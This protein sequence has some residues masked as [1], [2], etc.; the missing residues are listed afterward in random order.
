MADVQVCVKCGKTKKSTDFYKMRDGSRCDMCKACL[1]M[2]IDNRQPDTFLWILEKFDI[3]YIEDKWVELSNKKYMENPA[4][5][6]PMSVI[7]TYMRSM[8][9]NQYKDYRYADSD[10]L[11]FEA[12]KEREE[13]RAKR[14]ALGMDKEYEANLKA[15]L[16]NGEITE[17]E[18]NTLSHT[19]ESS[20]EIEENAL[21]A[22]PQFIQD[23][24]QLNE[25]DIK[26]ELSEDDIKYLAL[27]WGLFYKPSQWVWLEQKYQEYANQY[28]LSV[29]REDVLRKICKVSLKMDEALDLGDTKTFK[30]LSLTYESLRKSGKFTEAQKQEEERR[31]IDS[32]GELVAF[33]EKEGGAIPC[34]KDPIEYPQDKV[35]FT[36]R[37]MK[38]YVDKLVKEELGLSD[39]IESFIKKA[40][41][42]KAE[43][44]EDIMATNFDADNDEVTET[45][46]QNFQEFLQKE[47]EEESYKLAEE[48]A[49]DA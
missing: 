32:I 2:H 23:V 40:E 12:L 41:E 27:K 29:D 21:A 17:A 11:N 14:E 26:K 10:K 48:F 6:G 46:A 47:I 7:G 3:P 43:S 49:G 30:D 9:M 42:N 33:V 24:T 13:A 1:T 34:Y 35:D 44:V 22:P 20:A 36:I 19:T 4:K 5:F 39:L 45:E 38:H 18:Y 37:D 15:K 31:E 28:E 16:E 25:D 8:N